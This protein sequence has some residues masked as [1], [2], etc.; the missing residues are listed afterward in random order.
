[1][2]DTPGPAA[3]RYAVIR[4]GPE[5]RVVGAR[6]AIGHFPDRETALAAAGALAREALDSGHRAEVLIQ[7]ETGELTPAPLAGS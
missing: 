2:T 6:R 1:M 4:V 3:F 7:S 5:W